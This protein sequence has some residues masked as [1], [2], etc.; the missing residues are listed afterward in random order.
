MRNIIKK[1]LAALLLL[2]TSC[3]RLRPKE[4][5]SL[6]AIPEGATFALEGF[7]EILRLEKLE[8]NLGKNYDR[9]RIIDS[10]YNSVPV[11]ITPS[12][13]GYFVLGKGENSKIVT[14]SYEGKHKIKGSS[15]LYI[16]NYKVEVTNR[17]EK[18]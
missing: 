15:R 16:H 6:D 18:K 13:C 14:F 12:N 5:V 1:G 2:T 8:D 9:I 4:T 17:R 7:P 11:V 10:E 3:T